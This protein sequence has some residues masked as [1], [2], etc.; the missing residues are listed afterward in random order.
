M[1]HIYLS[2]SNPESGLSPREAGQLRWMLELVG[3]LTLAFALGIST[4]VQWLVWRS[5]HSGGENDEHGDF[6]IRIESRRLETMQHN[7]EEQ[8]VISQKLKE[9]HELRLEEKKDVKA[10]HEH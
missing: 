2:Q 6:K 10:M 4:V 1:G 5:I 7:I 8:K 9:A 3:G